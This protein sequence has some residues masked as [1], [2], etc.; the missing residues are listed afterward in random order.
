MQKLQANE[1][2]PSDATMNLTFWQ[3]HG[4]AFDDQRNVGDD[5]R[6]M[7]S[8]WIIPENQS[9]IETG[10]GDVAVHCDFGS[11]L[12]L[13]VRDGD[14]ARSHQVIDHFSFNRKSLNAAA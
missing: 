3:F 1:G 9:G 13:A 14:I 11:L 7:R 8:L 12:V 5:F 2:I 6:G 10:N 4:G